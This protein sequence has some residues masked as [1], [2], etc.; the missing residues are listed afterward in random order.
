MGVVVF[1]VFAIS[2][3]NFA[4]KMVSFAEL[5]III[6]RRFVRRRNMPVDITRA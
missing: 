4:L 1:I 2:G 3:A 5:I 6:K